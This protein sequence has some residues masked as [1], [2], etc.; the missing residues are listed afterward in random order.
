MAFVIEEGRP[1]P[2]DTEDLV[3]GIEVALEKAIEGTNQ[4]L[5][6]AALLLHQDMDRLSGALEAIAQGGA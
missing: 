2:H 4:I 3:D 1:L 6:L 5:C